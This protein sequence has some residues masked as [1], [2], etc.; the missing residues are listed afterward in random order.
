MNLE[1]LETETLA[2]LL[3]NQHYGEEGQTSSLTEILGLMDKFPNFIF[4]DDINLNFKT[5]F[6]QK[7][8]IRR[9]GAESEELFL[10]FWRETTNE[11]LIK[12]VPKIK[13]WLENF[14]K[15]FD[16]KVELHSEDT[17]EYNDD[18]ENTYYLNPVTNVVTRLKVQ[19]VDKSANS[20]QNTLTKDREVLQAVWG[21]TRPY[22]LEQIMNLKDIYLDLLNEY[23]TIFL[24]EY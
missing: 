24:G 4:G 13:T 11:L 6:M 16:F 3:E 5:L 14:E 8:D 10:H 19:D 2:E 1:L 21:K 23:E 20:G 12:Y 7:Y 15:L 17:T 9:I 22:I 18:T